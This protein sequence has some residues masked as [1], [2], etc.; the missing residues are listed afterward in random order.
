MKKKIWV[1]FII[2][3][4][5]F[6]AVFYLKDCEKT[7]IIKYV[8]E[9]HTKLQDYSEKISENTAVTIEDYDDWEVTY[10][11]DTNMVEFLPK[12]HF[13]FRPVYESVYTGFYYS[14]DDSPLG[15]QGGNYMFTKHNSGWIWYEDRETSDN[16]EYTEK[17][18]ENWYWFEIHF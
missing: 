13:S 16:W 11:P 15:F 4:I 12:N 7:K 18:M 14:S 3:F 6:I 17:I 5:V 1:V 10:W 2:V 9:N 8:K